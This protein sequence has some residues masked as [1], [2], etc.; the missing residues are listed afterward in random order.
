MNLSF[1]TFLSLLAGLSLCGNPASDSRAATGRQKVRPTAFVENL[2]Q[3]PGGVLWQAKGAGFEASFSRDSF[4]LHLFGAK[5][6][7]ATGS[8]KPKSA[9]GEN[10]GLPKFSDPGRVL[11]T[12]QRI[13]L[14]GIGPQARI[15]PLEP[16]PGKM[17]FFRGN[18]SKRWVRGAATYARLRYKN[19]YPGI[20]LLFYSNQGTLEYDFVVAPGA[21]P[22]SIRLRVE[23]GR[24][25]RITEHGVLQ[26]GEGA[27]AV[28][29]RPLL[30]QNMGSGKQAVEGKFIS[31]ADNTVGFQFRGYDASRTLVIDPAL[32]LSYSTYL[33][34]PHDDESTGIAV[35]AQGNSYILGWSGSTTYPVSANAYQP[36]RKLPGVLVNNMVVTKISPSGTLLYSTF[37]GGSTGETSGGIVLDAAGN[38]YVTGT[39][40]SADYPVTPGLYQGTYPNGAPNSLVVSEISPDGSALVYSTF[41]GGSGGATAA[42]GGGIALYQGTLY[43]AGSAGPGLPTTAGA[44]LSQINS[45][46]AA[47][48][49]TLNPAAVGPAQLVASTYYGAANP[50]ANSVLTGNGGYSMALDSSGNPWI[51]GQTW[52]NN[53]PT[54]ANALQPALPALSTTCRT[55]GANLNSAAYIAKLSSNLGSLLY[56]S[57][58]SGQTTGAQV[59]ACS[60]YGHL[61]ALDPSGNVYLTGATASASFPTTSGVVQASYPGSNNYVGFVSKLSSDGT[62]KLWSSYL[63]GNGG[64][65][66]PTWLAIDTQGNPWVGGTTQGGSNFPISAVTYQNTQ[67]GTA[68]GHLTEFSSD[69]TQTP[70][71][72]YIGGSLTDVVQSFGFDAQNNIYVAGNATSRNFPITANAFQP[73]FA[74]G[75]PVYDGGDIFFLILAQNAI[76]TSVGPTTV[77]NNGDTTITITGAAFSQGSSCSLVEGSTTISATAAVVAAD[78][79]SVTCTFSL[80]GATPSAYDLSITAPGNSTITK[81]AAITVQNGGQPSVS[82]SVVGRTLIR[83]GV[84]STYY[85]TVANSGTADAYYV[86]W[87]II[88]SPGLQFS[89]PAGPVQVSQPNTNAGLNGNYYTESDGTIVIPFLAFHIPAGSSISVPIQVTATGSQSFAVYG[90]VQAIWF[91][92]YADTV[93]AFASV[94]ANPPTSQPPCVSNALKPYLSNCLAS[95]VFMNASGSASGTQLTNTVSGLPN[96]TPTTVAQ[97]IP[98]TIQ[99]LAGQLAPP[100]GVSMSASAAPSTL[101]VVHPL[102]SPSGPAPTPAQA[103]TINAQLTIF[104]DMALVFNLYNIHNGVLMN[105]CQQVNPPQTNFLPCVGNQQVFTYTW[106]Y[107]TPPPVSAP[108]GQL[109]YVLVQGCGMPMPPPNPKFPNGNPFGTGAS[110]DPNYKSGPTGSGPSQYVAGTTPLTYNLGFENEPTATL[111]AANVVVTDQL[112]ATVFDLTT[113]TLKSIVIGGKVITIP[114]N[115]SNYTT[116]YALNSSLSVRIQ[117]SLNIDTGVLK[118]TFTSI[119]PST[120][121]PPS[122][123]TVGFLP[124]D[125]NGIVGQGSVTFALLPKSGLSTGTQIANQATVVFDA[126]API[127]TQTWMNTID[128]TPPTSAVGALPAVETVA[129][130][131][132][133]WA[134]SDIGSGI[135]AYSIYVSDNSGPFTAWLSQTTASTANYSGQPG[136]TY[137]FYS[138]AVDGAGNVQPGKT[139][140]DASTAVAAAVPNVVGLTQAAATTAITGAGLVLGTVTTASSSTVPSGSVVSESPV[141]GTSV[142]TGSA[143]NLVVSSGPAQVAVPNVVGLTQAAAT[144]AIT[145]AGLALGTVTTVSSGTVP[146]GSVISESPVAGTQVNTGS[147]VNLVVSSGPALKPQTITF[148]AIASK[149]QGKPLTLSASASSGLAVTF[150]SS[151]PTICTVSGNT[152]TLM[153]AGTCTIVASQPGNAVYAAATPV[154]QSFTVQAAY[155]ITPIPNAETVVVGD[156]AAFALEVHSTTGFNGNIT[157][158]CSGGPS[159]TSCADFP[160]TIRLINGYGLAISGILFPKNTPPGTYTVTFKGISGAITNSATA[161]FTVKAH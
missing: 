160:A 109:Q 152:A 127:N 71:S 92:S 38:A 45:G 14:A 64:Y 145:G 1:C 111:P 59:N 114:P 24:P 128:V 34:G 126:N 138:L 100:S 143:V 144:T 157:L 9:G 67:K 66:F 135:A 87:T 134:G 129:T 31:L 8:A 148:N 103:Q 4:V 29:H 107:V 90:G 97:L 75:G 113:L 55:S 94:W 26:V 146:S 123:P 78:G 110:G 3:A 37:L 96:A 30:Y 16:L 161:T 86:Q 23:D 40:K 131:P 73:L 72:T 27:E 155:T 105:G 12:E 10:G 19:V 151:T 48:V 7:A 159:G 77:G 104:G 120:G 156:I 25:F 6:E 121:L 80:N 44:Y 106:M 42:T 125:V 93:A 56:G 124:P 11:V 112:N 41:F 33:G 39:T 17:N 101:S 88:L 139:V 32:M 102:A 65:T 51:T 132:V 47:F 60:E 35:D 70:Y 79:T 28:S 158:S 85:I 74:N 15:E 36:E 89:F 18:N 116:V 84:P 81:K 63:G 58:F 136:H 141:A 117:G 142:N 43:F 46:Q 91:D 99:D 54:T 118:F 20:D 2:G 154:S 149:V 147:A 130:F 108:C 5:P 137:G 22:G 95:Q 119:D 69:G 76:V 115:T 98:L 49:A 21:D 57:Y 153:S 53:L 61:I 62:Q 68:N 13:S 50:A 150:T 133:S 52:T 82:A 140:P 83:E 122:D